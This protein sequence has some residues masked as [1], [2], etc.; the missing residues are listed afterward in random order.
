MRVHSVI[1]AAGGEDDAG[2]RCAPSRRGGD[3]PPHPRRPSAPAS[4]FH[5]AHPLSPPTPPTP[6]S[7]PPRTAAASARLLVPNFQSAGVIGKG[8]SVINALREET[9]A[10]IKVRKEHSELPPCAL[11]GDEL[12]A[13]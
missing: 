1:V 9:G 10:T 11:E 3:S 5:A 12:V 6:P 7:P 13:V 2:A 4:L 8:G